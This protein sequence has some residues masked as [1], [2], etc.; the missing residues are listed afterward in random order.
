MIITSEKPVILVGGGQ[1]DSHILHQLL[2]FGNRIVAADGGAQAVLESGQMPDAVIGD[3]DSLTDQMRAQIPQDRIFH[4][5]EQDS[6]DFDKALRNIAAPLVLA[7]GFLGK[8]TDHTLA[9]LNVLVRRGGCILVGDQDI[10][11][12]SP[13]H[14]R[15]DLTPGTVFSLFPMGPVQGQSTGLR[16]PI[17]GIDFTPGGRVGTSNETTGPVE[18]KFDTDQMLVVVPINALKDIIRLDLQ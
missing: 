12:R 3:M 13:R 7:T 8:R 9:T 2:T 15:L 18:L 17:D 10:I 6:T 14:L 1:V 11:F 16:W 4:I 5:A